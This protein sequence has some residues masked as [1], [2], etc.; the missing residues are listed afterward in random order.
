MAIKNVVFD[1][2]GTCTQ[3]PVIH[4][5]FLEKY[6][7]ELNKRIFPQNNF[8]HENWKNP[9]TSEEWLEAQKSVRESSPKA[10][11]TLA[12]TPAAPAAADPYILAF[13]SAK[14]IL[15][16]RRNGKG[17]VEIPFEL[18][19][20]ASDANEAPWRTEAKEVIETLLKKNINVYFISNSS[21][22]KITQ[23]LKELLQADKLPPNLKV[24]SDA[25]KFR[26]TELPI[27]DKKLTIPPAVTAAF[28]ALPPVHEL[29]A[30]GRPVYLR[31]GE[32]FRAICAVLNNNP[33]AISDTVFC[34]DIW[35]MDHAMPGKLGGKIHL[36]KRASPFDTCQFEL[37]AVKAANGKISEDLKGLLE[38]F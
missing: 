11:W 10:G 2:D 18:H 32:Y 33:G 38:W 22:G 1:F 9:V 19:V 29:S 12:T 21:S 34:G 14:L 23:R 13:E 5:K 37:D 3:I 4:E 31:R 15:R 20:N 26:I 8:S 27:I 24:Q 7:T 6:L 28:E 36:I 30:E 16:N 35:E 25:M 17:E